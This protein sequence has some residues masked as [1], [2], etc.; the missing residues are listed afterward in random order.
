MLYFINIRGL[1]FADVADDLSQRPVMPT[2]TRDVAAVLRCEGSVC[3]N[4]LSWIW[5]RWN[6]LDVA[7]SLMASDFDNT[8][9][10]P[11]GHRLALLADMAEGLAACDRAD[12]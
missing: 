6:A 8:A 4:M 1:H 5:L 10:L 7:R 3:C 12:I 11:H 2:G 9:D